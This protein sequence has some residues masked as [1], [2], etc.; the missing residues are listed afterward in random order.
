VPHP[1]I[2]DSGCSPD[3][4]VGTDG[5]VEIKCPIT[6]THIETLTG[7]AVPVK[8]V[9]QIQWQLACTGRQWADFVSYDPRMP[10]AMKFFCIRVYRVPEII[11]ELEREVITFLN[12]IR[13]SIDALQSIYDPQPLDSA[14]EILMAG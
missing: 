14:A 12:E 3:G 9:T 1:S 7:K 2:A 13:A 6:A 8:Y 4:L 11:E 5:L 10:E